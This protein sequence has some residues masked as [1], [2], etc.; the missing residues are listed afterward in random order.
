MLAYGTAKFELSEVMED[1]L[2]LET[3]L[4]SHWR[5]SGVCPDQLNYPDLPYELAHIWEWWIDLQ[6]TAPIG[7][8]RSHINY[9]EIANWSTL[10]K[11]NI[12]PFE[13][14]CIMALDSAHMRCHSEQREKKK[15]SQSSK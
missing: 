6:S 2:T 1:G 13:I 11:I 15:P 4:T 14:R 12:T 8:E 7:M 5:Q 9:T 10:L 3:H